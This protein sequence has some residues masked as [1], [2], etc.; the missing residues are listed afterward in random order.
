[1]GGK[2]SKPS[3]ATAAD[4]NG[5]APDGRTGLDKAA[6]I[7]RVVMAG[8]PRIIKVKRIIMMAEFRGKVQ[9]LLQAFLNKNK[10]VVYGLIDRA[11][12][13]KATEGEAE[14][15]PA[16]KGTIDG[17]DLV[18]M[19]PS[20]MPAL[21]M[22]VPD[23]LCEI[24]EMYDPSL[25]DVMPKDADDTDGTATDEEIITAAVEVA[26]VVGPFFVAPVKAMLALVAVTKE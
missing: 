11:T 1:M 23:L 2:K 17:K 6:G 10:A 26:N 24:L 9:S 21:I 18:D 12:E 22:D 13:D 19:L 7:I 25:S 14:T 5:G 15:A 3:R 8:K 20:L 16:K 4:G